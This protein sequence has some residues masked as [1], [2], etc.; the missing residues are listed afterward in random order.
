QDLTSGDFVL[1]GGRQLPPNYF[2]DK[3]CV[4]AGY[5]RAMGIRLLSGREFNEN[6]DG[7]NPGVVIVSQ[8][9]AARIWPGENPLG[10]RI[11]MADRPKP[12]DW[13]SVV[14][15]VNDVRQQDL[16]RKPHPAVYQSY[17]QVAS[18]GFLRHMTFILKTISSPHSV[19]PAMRAVLQ[20]VDR[21]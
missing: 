17:K 7:A 4:S 2:V 1:E 14:G 15:V 16:T 6:D 3:P 12:Q 11:S 8:S 18:P 19:A 5:F 13:L 10:K 9:V 20:E 21:N